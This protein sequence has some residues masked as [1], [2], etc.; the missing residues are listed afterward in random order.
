MPIVET[1][2]QSIEIGEVKSITVTEVAQDTETG[3]YV[4]EIRV[5]RARGSASDET[6]SQM[7]VLSV[8]LRSPTRK[9]VHIVVPEGLEF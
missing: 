7:Q 3:E 9:Q 4:R 8:R 1:T 5:F 6:E 2:Q